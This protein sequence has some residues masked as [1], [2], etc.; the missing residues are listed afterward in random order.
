MRRFPT[1]LAALAAV[2]WSAGASAA[3][4]KTI[5]PHITVG[6]GTV[7][8][9]FS[10]PA[11]LE[12]DLRGRISSGLTNR[13]LVSAWIETAGGEWKGHE[14]LVSLQAVYDVWDEQYILKRDDVSG[15]T[16]RRE[17]D[18]AAFLD[19]LVVLDRVPLAAAAVLERSKQYVVRV[20]VSVNPPSPELLEKAREY[21][22]DPEGFKRLSTSRTAFGS[23]AR[24]FI[25]AAIG[26]SGSVHQFVSKPFSPA[27]LVSAP[28]PQPPAEKAAPG[29]DR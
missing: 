2:A 19:A 28:P 15:S 21:L 27:A 25:P 3:E 20:S 8:A 5:A 13:I 16:T 7:H 23:F 10:I 29:G 24:T 22:S 14:S 12:G 1:C 26:E 4:P 6:A 11:I 17:K 18:P 9:S